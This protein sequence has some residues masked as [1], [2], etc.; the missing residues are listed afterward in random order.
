MDKAK[1]A[2]LWKLIRVVFSLV[3]ITRGVF[4]KPGLKVEDDQ[5]GR[6]NRL[7]EPKKTWRSRTTLT[8]PKDGVS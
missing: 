2:L 8:H 1:Q 3:F 6:A 4:L 5:Q 7:G